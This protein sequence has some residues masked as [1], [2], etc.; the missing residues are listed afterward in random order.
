MM[1]TSPYWSPVSSLSSWKFWSILRAKQKQVIAENLEDF[2][3]LTLKFVEIL[4]ILPNQWATTMHTKKWRITYMLRDFCSVWQ[5]TLGPGT[6]RWAPVSELKRQL[7]RSW[8]VETWISLRYQYHI[9]SWQTIPWMVETFERHS[10]AWV[11][12]IEG[13]NL[14]L[15]YFRLL[16]LG[17]SLCS[18]TI[19]RMDVR[20]APTWNHTRQA[21]I[22]LCSKYIS[23]E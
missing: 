15:I 19:C 11:C 4:E 5:C 17:F 8:T 23:W 12:P 2:S 16:L 13:S 20:T 7:D 3:E 10:H 21:L 9:Q 18:W 14:E 6:A 1:F 22:F